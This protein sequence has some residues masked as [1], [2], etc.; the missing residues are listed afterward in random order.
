MPA[1]FTIL[2][3][4][5]MAQI[6]AHHV[7]KQ[8]GDNLANAVLLLPT[9]RACTLMRLAL[10]DALGGKTVL[11]PRILP[12]GD[13]EQELPGLLPPSLLGKLASIPPAMPE[14]RRL[15][16]LMQQVI[17]FERGRQ[18]DISFAHAL[19]L[20]NDLAKLQDQCARN[21]VPLTMDRLRAMEI[22][23]HYAE[24][25]ESSLKFLTIVAGT[26]PD[27]EREEGSIIATK[28]QVHLLTLLAEAWETTPPS[29]PVF[30]IGS[31]ASQPITA[32]LIRAIAA[33][34]GGEVI[35]PG[36]DPQIDEP[37]W[38]CITAG[39]PLFHIKSLLDGWNLK[40][41]EVTLLG[42]AVPETIWLNALACSDDVPNW[43]NYQPA[44]HD[45]LKLI[46]CAHG[47][48]E[49][50]VLT[51]LIREALEQGKRT[52]LVTPDEGLMQR[53]GMH[54]KRYN[55]TPDRLKQGTLA[56][57][58]T[59]S[60]WLAMMQFVA[61]PSR[62]L[63]LLA[64]LR[65]PLLETQWHAWLLEAEPEFRGLVNHMPGQLPR[66]SPELRDRPEHAAAAG[67]IRGLAALNRRR[68]L[69]SQWLEH[70]SALAQ[71]ENGEGAEAVS[72]ALEN[73]RYADVLGELDGDGFT[74]LLTEALGEAWRGG[75]HEAHPGITMLTPVEARLQQFDRILLANM[76]DQL[77]PGLASPSAWLNLAQ[78]QAL[79]LPSPEEH[80]SL[81]AHD[82]LLLGSNAEVVMTCPTREQG[83]PTT[84]SR[85]IERL[86]AFLAVHGIKKETLQ[87]NHYLH[88]AHAMHEATNYIPAEAPQPKPSRDRRPATMN[89]SHLDYMASD[90]YWLYARY[91]LRLREMDPI[92]AE[93]EAK[94][95]GIIIHAAMKQLT[96]HWEQTQ[97]PAEPAELAAILRQALVPFE[98]RPEA[99]LFWQD[100]LSRALDYV[101]TQEILRHTEPVHVEPEKSVSQSIGAL[102]LQGRIDRLEVGMDGVRIGDYKT[103]EAPT[104]KKI[105][106][107]EAMQLLAY[108]MLLEAEGKPVAGVDYW[109]LP[110]GRRTGGI[111]NL[112]AADMRANGLLEKLDAML[113]DLMNP[114]TAL[115]AKPLNKT[116]RY[117][118]PYDG[119][120]R[121]DEWAG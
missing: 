71:V 31:T 73:L 89:V 24:H 81:M 55:I 65:H 57:T 87:A 95:L 83:S 50:R 27:I 74:A 60:L 88:W 72:E 6:A 101:N 42:D 34:A 23:A 49:A 28:R 32:R 91:V 100:R 48:E 104:A 84:P 70:L 17:A 67:L 82:I 38:A 26:W 44:A 94:E 2:P 90:P 12:I 22:P 112:D 120:S 10:L 92:D 40:P 99:R 77:W 9:R 58:E 43:R 1:I 20:A 118:N 18:G 37:R 8:V 76:Q 39:H 114:G 11:L 62:V 21:G 75:I 98:S 110:A 5:P 66:L 16:L 115:L 59:G 78:Q 119:I 116:E 54:L 52:A 15:G 111:N 113:V 14:W 35:L 79:G 96:Q 41:S 108:A 107:G 47:E 63:P 7:L 103:G 33:S 105:L 109:E 106:N 25:W 85:F 121:Y 3:G 102:K 13:L 36:L 4:Q 93:P 68:F 29:M 53:V 86:I 117:A 46:A 30:A 64:L 56:T 51:L 61:T 19:G 45:H 80:T 69:P 97:R